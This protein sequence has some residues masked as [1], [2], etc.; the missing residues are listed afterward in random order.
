[1][2]TYLLVEDDPNDARLVT[3]ALS[4]VEIRWVR[5]ATDALAQM[6]GADLVLLDLG[7][8]DSEGFD[9]V[10]HMLENAPQVPIVVLTGTD[11]P[12][13][14]ALALEAGAQEYVLKDHM[15]EL[16]SRVEAALT[17][18][19]HRNRALA[20]A[21]TA[22]IRSAEFSDQALEPVAAV[23]AAE[24]GAARL[25]VAL[26]E[27]FNRL[28]GRYVELLTET[29]QSRAYTDGHRPL[30]EARAL[31]R[32]VGLVNGSPRDLVDIHLQSLDL[33]SHRTHPERLSA[34]ADEGRVLLL[35]VVGYLALH[36]RDHAPLRAAAGTREPR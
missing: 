24:L 19:R 17:R 10:T 35:E 22:G 20:Q 16:P 34:L 26:P 28:V 3:E 7:L 27:L 2:T 25:R 4:D 31:T 32:E 30:G 1:M 5:R 14:R 15:A 12:T 36:Y 13:L 29:L 23:A 6:E 11:D 8:P 33:L 21:L 18:Q 9:T